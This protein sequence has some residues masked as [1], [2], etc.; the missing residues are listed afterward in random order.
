M[1]RDSLRSLMRIKVACPEFEAF[2]PADSFNQWL[3]SGNRHIHG[4]ELSGPKGP[5]A[6]NVEAAD[7]DLINQNTINNIVLTVYSK[8]ME[9]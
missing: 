2:S 7:S 1:K 5:R 9:S 8:L 3:E 4:H 6:P